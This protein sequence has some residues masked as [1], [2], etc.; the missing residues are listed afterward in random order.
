MV[1]LKPLPIITTQDYFLT[2][3][4][5]VNMDSLD[6]EGKAREMTLRRIVQEVNRMARVV[7]FWVPSHVG[8]IP[9]AKV[10]CVAKACLKASATVGVSCSTDNGLKAGWLQRKNGRGPLLKGV[11]KCGIVDS[12]RVAGDGEGIGEV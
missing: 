3:Y 9:N 10:D 6:M 5:H 8:F 4:E 11:Y 2:F 12:Q 1:A 7:F